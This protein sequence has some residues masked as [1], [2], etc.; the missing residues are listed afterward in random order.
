MLEQGF[1]GVAARIRSQTSRIVLRQEM[2]RIER[3]LER[4]NE[5][6]RD[7]IVLRKLQELSFAEIGERLG[8]SPDA[9]RMQLARAMTALT[10][11]L[12]EES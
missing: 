9:C 11:A 7:V 4:I 3:A 8:R 1:D 10:R 12:R 2:E 5:S 6:H